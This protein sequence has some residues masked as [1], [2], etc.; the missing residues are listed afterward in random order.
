MPRLL[1]PLLAVLAAS[2]ALERQAAALEVVVTV[3]P[4]EIV[5]GRAATARVVAEVTGE[6]AERVRSV[7]LESSVGALSAPR[8]V[9]PRTW[10]ATYRLPAEPYPQLA[11]LLA[12]TEGPEVEAYGAAVAR[13]LGQTEIAFRT[14]PGATVTVDAGG[15]TFGPTRAGPDGVARL[16]IVVGPGQSTV[17][18]TSVDVVGNRSE[19]EVTLS[20]PDYR[21][22][23]LLGPR[24][25]VA[26]RPATVAVAAVDPTGAPAHPA[27]LA[28]DRGSLGEARSRPGSPLVRLVELE[29]PTQVGSGAVTLRALSPG[30]AGTAAETE[31]AVVPDRAEAVE[32]TIDRDT[33]VPGSS[34]SV[35]VHAAVRDRHGNTHST[36]Q[37]SLTV[38]GQPILA[39]PSS[40][41]G[42]EATLRAPP[43]EV[44][45][46]AL[47]VEARSRGLVD[48]RR[49]ELN[50][51]PAV[52]ARIEAPTT[53]VAD[54]RTARPIRVLLVGATGLP[55]DE[56]PNIRARQ[57][58]L[59]DLR[60]DTDGW[61][62]VEWVPRR[63]TFSNLGA[64]V[65]EAARGPATARARIELTP[66]V[67][68]FTVAV[69]LGLRT[70]IGALVGPQGELELAS[71]VGLRHGW[72]VLGL[73]TGLYCAQASYQLAW[74]QSQLRFT[75]VPLAGGFGYGI[76]LRGRVGINLMALGGA[77]FAVVEERTSFRPST[78]RLWTTPMVEGTFDVSI[79]L[80]PGELFARLGFG[81]A[82]A[83]EG[84][85]LRG[86]L[87][88]LVALLGYRIF[89]V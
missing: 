48:R 73:R 24:A 7:R 74:G 17:V 82:A 80:G 55:A 40:E 86:N 39:A 75:D 70:N 47:V 52:L 3:S 83:P 6:G 61:W 81:Y 64:D 63:S 1:P 78:G 58:R 85:G 2:L 27:E 10:E 25:V 29:P 60:R 35:T 8:R 87:L 44:G 30:G 13:L 50:G 56:V 42:V 51:G 32:L 43:A 15:A 22:V 31:V 19:R 57:G 41:G 46:G 20:L 45:L 76:T 9:G 14:D 28:V 68:W 38:S 69:S 54:G 67:P 21:R 77:L 11:L 62:Q 88:G 34:Q 26:G 79:A 5:L 37:I 66:P 49:I 59:R 23:V 53:A 36:D 18:A 16:A 12:R 72:L 33:L 89:V 65:I 84:S 71:R 4:A